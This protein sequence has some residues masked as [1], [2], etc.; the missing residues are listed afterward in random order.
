MEMRVYSTI[1]ALQKSIVLENSTSQEVSLESV[2]T[3]M[4]LYEIWQNG[5]RMAGGMLQ[6][7]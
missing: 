2:K 7:K 4:Y 6:V 5:E 1:G 3:G